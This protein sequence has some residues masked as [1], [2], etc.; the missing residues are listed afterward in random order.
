MDYENIKVAILYICTG[1]YDIFWPEFYK[2]YEEF[3]LPEVNKTYIVFTDKDIPYKEN[4]NVRVVYQEHLGW[5]KATLMRYHMFMGIAEKLR[6]YTHIFFMN[7]NCRCVDYIYA[8]D[9]IVDD[10]LV[11][12]EHPGFYDKPCDKFTYERNPLSTAY[13][14]YGVGEHYVFGAVNGGTSEAFLKMSSKIKKNTDKDLDNNIIALW[15]DE[16]HLNRYI[17]D[18]KNY[19]LLSPSYAYP[20]GWKK[21]IPFTPKIYTVDKSKWLNI[22]EIKGGN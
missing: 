5:P 9:M 4:N 17:I 13:I 1:K 11:V 7:A 18:E 21:I 12:V 2:S 15:H 3:F 6:N 20:D 14:P 19:K 16:S 10:G 8:E 22:K